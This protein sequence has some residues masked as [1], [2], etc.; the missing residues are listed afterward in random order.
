MEDFWASAIQSGCAV[1]GAGY[2]LVRMESRLEELT[3]AIRDLQVAIV[4]KGG[5]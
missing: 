3:K 1:A 4:N 2:L 5:I